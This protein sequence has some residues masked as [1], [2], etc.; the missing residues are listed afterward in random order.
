MEGHS[1]G[2]VVRLAELAARMVLLTRQIFV[3]T[4]NRLEWHLDDEVIKL[5]PQGTV[6]SC[7]T[8]SESFE[9]LQSS[10]CC[11]RQE[12]RPQ[13]ILRGFCFWTAQCGTSMVG[14]EIPRYMSEPKRGTWA[15]SRAWWL[16]IVWTVRCEDMA[17]KS[18]RHKRTLVLTTVRLC[19]AQTFTKKQLQ[20]RKE[21]I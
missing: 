3:Y 10:C 20:N 12:P 13:S 2:A 14:H 16:K 18:R 11:S 5:T 8:A 17:P 19:F 6:W 7:R 9:S 21:I 1:K 4:K 15:K